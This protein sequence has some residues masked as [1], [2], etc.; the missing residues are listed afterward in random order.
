MP[1]KN[2]P[3]AADRQWVVERRE[4]IDFEI[5]FY[6]RILQRNP[7]YIDVLKRQ[8]ELLSNRGRHEEALLCDAKIVCELPKN[9]EAH[10][11]L[12]CSQACI[13]RIEESIASLTTALDLGYSD[14]EHLKEDADLVPLWNHPH[15]IALLQRYH[16]L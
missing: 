6:Q 9:A 8:G 11:N 5:D 14:F 16:M 2:T 4:Q 10:Y 7:T 12:A 3:H 1:G 15:F 13:G